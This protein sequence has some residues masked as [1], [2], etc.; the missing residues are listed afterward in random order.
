[1][2]LSLVRRTPY[3]KLIFF[4]RPCCM[5]HAWLTQAWRFDAQ[6][7]ANSKTLTRVGR[8]GAPALFQ[9]HAQPG[10]DWCLDAQQAKV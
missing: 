7:R 9:W 6:L 3:R 1:M 10:P 4:Q 2:T 8:P 5:A